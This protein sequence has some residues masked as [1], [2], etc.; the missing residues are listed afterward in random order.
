MIIYVQLNAI[1]RERE[2]LQK[3]G[4]YWVCIVE[5]GYKHGVIEPCLCVCV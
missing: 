1:D 5:N 3:A 2:V 4:F